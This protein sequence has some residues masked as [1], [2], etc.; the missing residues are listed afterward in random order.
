MERQQHRRVG[1]RDSHRHRSC[2]QPYQPRPHSGQHRSQDIPEILHMRPLRALVFSLCYHEAVEVSRKRRMPMKKKH[3]AALAASRVASAWC[4]CHD[5]KYPAE[6]CRRCLSGMA[7]GRCRSTPHPCWPMIFRI[8][9]PP[10]WKWMSSTTSAMRRSP[11]RRRFNRRGRMFSRR[12]CLVP[13]TDSIFSMAKRFRRLWCAKGL[14]H[15][16]GC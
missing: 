13:S 5:R 12:M 9:R 8:C 1:C 14:R 16:G 2:R 10:M 7:I 4:I 15:S 11:M 3:W 6:E